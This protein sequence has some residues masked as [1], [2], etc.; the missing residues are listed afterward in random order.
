MRC[1]DEFL[2]H[3]KIILTIKFNYLW[4]NLDSKRQNSEKT[5]RIKEKKKIIILSLKKCIWNLIFFFLYSFFFKL[6][7][8]I[9]FSMKDVIN[10]LLHLIRKMSSIS[11]LLYFY[12]FKILSFKILLNELHYKDKNDEKFDFTLFNDYLLL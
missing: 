12:V 3:E 5:S 7:L 1:N 2:N 9:V 8:K 10:H 4:N 6:I 11:I